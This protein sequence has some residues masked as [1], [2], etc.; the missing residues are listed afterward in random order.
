MFGDIQAKIEKDITFPQI[1]ALLDSVL[2]PVPNSE[3][4]KMNQLNCIQFAA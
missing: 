3:T 4:A 1:H 2:V